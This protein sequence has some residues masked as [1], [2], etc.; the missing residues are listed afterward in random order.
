MPPITVVRPPFQTVQDVLLSFNP[1]SAGGNSGH[2]LEHFLNALIPGIRDE[3][4]RAPHGVVAPFSIGRAPL[5]T[6]PQV[7]SASPTALQ[8]KDNKFRPV[9]VRETLPKLTAQVLQAT[10]SDAM[11]KLLQLVQL[12][13]GPPT[14]CHSSSHTIPS[15]PEHRAHDDASPAPVSSSEKGSGCNLP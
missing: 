5:T 8:K 12:G 15:W 9:A 2:C 3:V 14:G 1:V 6:R 7:V 13:F 4:V 10:E 11:A